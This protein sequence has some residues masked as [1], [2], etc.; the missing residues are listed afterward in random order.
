MKKSWNYFWLVVCLFLSIIYYVSSV[1][2]AMNYERTWELGVAF[3]VGLEFSF[4]MFIFVVINFIKII[5]KEK[6]GEVK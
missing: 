1:N 4:F 5:I 3:G 2:I 6:G